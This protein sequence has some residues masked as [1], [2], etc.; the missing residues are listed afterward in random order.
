MTPSP[1]SSDHASRV[2]RHASRPAR[3]PW[4]RRIVLTALAVL[5]LGSVALYVYGLWEARQV[6]LVRVDLTFDGLP[7]A[8]DGL[9]IL[10]VSDLH[11]DHFGTIEQRLRRVLLDTPADLLVCT[12]DF[13]ATLET[14][15]DAVFAS[16]DRIFEGL[17]YPWG[18]FACA[19]NDD[20]PVFWER[21]KQ[22]GP[23]HGFHRSAML[24]EHGGQRIALLGIVTVRPL[25]WIRGEHEIDECTWPRNVRRRPAPWRLLPDAPARPQAAHDLSEGRTF[26]IL[27]AHNPDTIVAAR[28]AGID[29]LLCG[30]THGGQ[31]NLPLLGPLYRHC[32]AGRHYNQG[33]FTEGPT[34]MYISPGIG[35][36]YLPIRIGVPP[37]VTLLTL[38]RRAPAP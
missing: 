8:F 31:V 25:D 3:G 18:L 11:T 27:L 7:P 15:N 30:D 23:F 14:D 12:G 36:K 28:D 37:E 19:G 26:R 4:R 16:L 1:S 29:L 21:L 20:G 2:T 9:R 17:D 10:H 38:H 22:R 13:R 6:G 34:Q 24:L 33:H 35:T 5:A 32:R